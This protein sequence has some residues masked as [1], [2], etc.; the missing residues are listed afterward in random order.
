MDCKSILLV[1]GFGPFR[2]NFVLLKRTR[3]YAVKLENVSIIS[4]AL[5]ESIKKRFDGELHYH[6]LLY[7]TFEEMIG[8]PFPMP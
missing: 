4:L 1:I 7:A 8:S 3:V 2:I 5:Y 6:S